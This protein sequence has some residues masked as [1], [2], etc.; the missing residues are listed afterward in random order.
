MLKKEIES[1][2]SNQL[3]DKYNEINNIDNNNL[4]EF[5]IKAGHYRSFK[6]YQKIKLNS[7][8]DATKSND[9]N[10]IQKRKQIDLFIKK[11]SY[12]VLTNLETSL[13]NIFIHFTQEQNIIDDDGFINTCYLSDSIYYLTKN[14]LS[15]K[16]RV[17][18]FRKNLDVIVRNAPFEGE[19]SK[20]LK[21]Q[22]EPP[23]WVLLHSYSFGDFAYLFEKM[24]IE[25]RKQFSIYIGLFTIKNGEKVCID[26]N[27]KVTGNLLYKLSAFR[28]AVMHDHI[29]YGGCIND[30]TQYN[31]EATKDL[32]NYII[33]LNEGNK[34]E[35]INFKSV[36]DYIIIMVIFSKEIIHE[37]YVNNELLYDLN[38]FR[39]L[40][41]EV[42]PNEKIIIFGENYDGKI[43]FS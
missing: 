13:K 19:I 24:R 43:N 15:D 17:K 3:R 25:F 16:D 41:G 14:E 35:N 12:S 37:Q 20:C 22:S 39:D 11:I 18:I 23:I 40:L 42:D 4:V 10:T 26:S 29:I 2:T 32:K 33:S 7:L 6:Q 34:F 38:R 36:L 27:A 30:N 1:K 21:N 9:F 8:D 31:K 28:N 5:I